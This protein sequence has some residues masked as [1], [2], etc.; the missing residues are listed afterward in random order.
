LLHLLDAPNVAR[1]D[2]NV[3]ALQSGELRRFVDGRFRA[4]EQS[5]A[6]VLF[7]ERDGGGAAHA[8]PGSGDDCGSIHARGCN[9]KR[10]V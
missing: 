2:E 7:C 5:H 3:V 9:V 1:N 4:A 10:E 8:A 6:P